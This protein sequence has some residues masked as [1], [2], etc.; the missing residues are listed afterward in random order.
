MARPVDPN[1]QYTIKP[2]IV[3]SYTYA[4][5]QPPYI[6]PVTGA[7]KYKYIHW[8]TVDENLKFKPGEPFFAASPNERARL[9]FPE[10]W[11]ISEA[12]KLERVNIK[13]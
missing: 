1:A 2:H 5:T 8:G 12:E 7:K 3:N 13:Y 11:D 9:I 10:A 4:S 6:D